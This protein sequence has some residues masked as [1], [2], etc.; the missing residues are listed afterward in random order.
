MSCEEWILISNI[1]GRRI[2]SFIKLKF[3]ERSKSHYEHFTIIAAYLKSRG[4]KIVRCITE[5]LLRFSLKNPKKKN[6]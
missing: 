6:G 4:E 3:R 2:G 5:I 1:I